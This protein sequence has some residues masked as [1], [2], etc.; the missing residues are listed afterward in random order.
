MRKRV[1]SLITLL[2]LA[3]ALA[4]GAYA[5]KHHKAHHKKSRRHR[6]E[7]SEDY[8]PI[9]LN[10][11]KPV[12][13]D[14]CTD[15]VSGD[16]VIHFAES[17]IGVHYRPAT[18]DPN[19]GFDCSGFV[20]YVFKSFNFSVPR[21]SPEFIN[22]GE[23][24]SLAD[25]KPGDIIIFTSPQRHSHRIGHVGIVYSNDNDGIKFIHST[26]GKEYG[27]TITAMDDT[28]MNRFVQIVRVL[29]QNDGTQSDSNTT[30]SLAAISR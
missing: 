15:S 25:S 20:S 1:S 11:V 16:N 12:S 6:S 13:D 19:V 4:N 9:S 27:V 17:M 22:I 14:F 23:K 2:C 21:S 30:A 24:V 29:K 3:T 18:S 26:S 10:I 28:Y 7:I 8:T 5:A